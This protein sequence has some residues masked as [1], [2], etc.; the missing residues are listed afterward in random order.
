MTV[1]A[2][3][4]ILGQCSLNYANCPT[5]IIVN[6][7]DGDG[8]GVGGWAVPQLTVLGSCA[9]TNN[10]QTGGP[11]P[12]SVLAV[13]NYFVNYTAYAV[14]LSNFTVVTTT[15]SF[16]VSITAQHAETCNG[17]DDNCNGQV[18][19]GLLTTYYADADGDGY[20]NANSS[21]V[22]CTFP[23]G[24]ALN[25]TDC[26][27]NNATAYPGNTEVCNGTDDNCNTQVD[28][29]LLT[30]YYADTDGDGYG[31][32]NSSIVSCSIPSGYVLDICDCND[33]S[34]TAHP[35]GNEVANGIDDDCNGL[36]DDI[37]INPAT[38]TVVQTSP[39]EVVLNWNDIPLAT[40][41]QIQYRTVGSTAYLPTVGAGTSIATLTALT[42]STN[43][44][45]RI[46]TRC[47]TSYLPYSANVPFA[48]VGSTG[49]C[50]KPTAITAHPVSNTTVKL[51]WKY[52]PSATKYSVRYRRSD[53]PTWVTKLLTNN[54]TN[55]TIPNLQAGV[56]YL[57][58]VRSLCPPNTASS[59]SSYSS[60]GSF[61]MPGGAVYT[62]GSAPIAGSTAAENLVVA[63]EYTPTEVTISPNPTDGDIR[64]ISQ[65]DATMICRLY[66]ATGK[67]LQTWQ[68]VNSG[69]T[70]PISSKNAGFYILQIEMPDG[71]VAVKPIVK[72]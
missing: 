52:V 3:S 46:R 64:V 36:V 40:T 32:P 26:N 51:Y 1:S 31:N 18:D 63:G 59:W 19:E 69:D 35:G 6:D 62:C 8:F 42:P 24:Y 15:C 70:L 30:T 25:A 53:S 68:A 67:L 66:D 55:T 50:G 44:E 43:Y 57:Y 7:C 13:G 58:Q 5:A 54:T 39:T 16:Q 27:D 21:I 22:S 4:G 14:D 37:C 48:T 33:N 29:G 38:V 56:T 41:H 49:T 10:S 45:Y 9:G 60:V 61:Q 34:A 11:A 72:Q 2:A 12:D 47:G 17:I 28:E 65:G 20:G 23:S 71:T